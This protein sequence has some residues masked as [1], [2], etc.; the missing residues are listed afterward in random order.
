MK[1][2]AFNKISFL[3]SLV[4]LNK[5][6]SIV[7]QHFEKTVISSF[8]LNISFYLF[9]NDDLNDYLFR[10]LR[11]GIFGFLTVVLILFMG[12]LFSSVLGANKL[13][14]NSLDISLASTG[15]FLKYAEKLLKNLLMHQNNSRN[16]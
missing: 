9:K 3:F 1:K 4:P 6:D 13:I 2:W 15:F 12:E 5:T 8:L 16:N 14:F 11:A 7:I 10:P